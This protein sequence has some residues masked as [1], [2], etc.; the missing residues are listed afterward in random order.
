[1]AKNKKKHKK[2]SKLSWPRRTNLIEA[3]DIFINFR[4]LCVFQMDLGYWATVDFPS[5]HHINK[6]LSLQYMDKKNLED[7]YGSALIKQVF[8]LIPFCKS[9]VAFTRGIRNEDMES[10]KERSITQ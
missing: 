9:Y 10:K 2:E 1:M 6:I 7:E 4:E 3:V 5:K 8:D